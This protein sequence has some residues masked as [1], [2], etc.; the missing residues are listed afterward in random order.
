MA[1]GGLLRAVAADRH[2]APAPG[3]AARVVDEHQR[4]GRPLACLDLGEILLARSRAIASTIGSSR[5]PAS[6]SGGGF[7]A[8]GLP[9]AR[10]PERNPR[11][12]RASG[13]GAG[14]RAARPRPAGGPSDS[15]RSPRNHSRRPAP[16]LRRCRARPAS[17]G[18]A[19]PPARFPGPSRIAPAMEQPVAV[20]QPV[21][22]GVDRRRDRVEDIQAERVGQEHRRWKLMAHGG[23]GGGR[24]TDK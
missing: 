7:A 3:M 23:L 17:P 12:A 22:R 5:S 19:S 15:G 1:V 6:A 18:P 24:F 9:R 10:R 2:A 21:D 4:A 14:G 13:S 8:P 20:R 11:P 16:G